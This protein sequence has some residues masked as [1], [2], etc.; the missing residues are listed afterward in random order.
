M[1]RK[2][3]ITVLLLV[4]AGTASM[5]LTYDKKGKLTWTF[6]LGTYSSNYDS[7]GIPKAISIRN[8]PS[9]AFLARLGAALPEAKD[10]RKTNPELI[11]DDVG[12]N[13]RMK[14]DGDVYVTFIHEGAGYKNGF[15]FFTFADGEAPATKADVAETVVFP[16]ASFFNSGGSSNGLKSGDTQK[17]GSF[18]AGTNIG[19]FVAANGFSSSTGLTTT[20]TGGPPGGDWIFYTTKALNSESNTALRAHTVLLADSIS[21]TVV[22]GLEDMLR[23]RS[24]CDHDFNDVVFTV[25]SDPPDA[26]GTEDLAPMPDDFDSD[27]DGV[28]DADDDYPEDPDRAFDDVYLGLQGHGTLAF[29]DSWPLH[30]DYDFNDLVVEYHYTR[31]LNAANELVDIV[32]QYRVLANGSDAAIGFGLAIPGLVP[33]AVGSATLAIGSGCGFTSG[34]RR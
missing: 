27:D 28:L 25:Y 6:L 1:N 34:A 20:P 12:A 9:D 2:R 5:G 22:L 15:G 4:L 7:S 3:V 11:A 10:I 14:K 33:S 24:D 19:F 31:V 17:M 8:P 21:G 16:N 23:T 29:E 13:L 26:I 32:A 18:S 30:G